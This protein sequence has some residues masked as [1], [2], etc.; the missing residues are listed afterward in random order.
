MMLYVIRLNSTKLKE[1][2]ILKIF[3]PAQ[4]LE[5]FK[6]NTTQILLRTLLIN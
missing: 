3:D 4:F 2:A 6:I 1:R 5:P